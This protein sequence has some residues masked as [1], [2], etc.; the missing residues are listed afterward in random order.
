MSQKYKNIAPNNNNINKNNL[1]NNNF[2]KSS[3][4]IFQHNWIEDR[5]ECIKNIKTNIQYDYL[6][7]V[8]RKE[9]VDEIVAVMTNAI[10]SNKETISIGGEQIPKYE[11]EKRLLLLD[12]GH[13]EYVYECLKKCRTQIK[14]MSAYLLSCLYHA[15]DVI[16]LHYVNMVNT[17]RLVAQ[18]L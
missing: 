17:D 2:N 12:C 9:I 7:T 6:V 5:I 13:I 8:F 14:N 1:N 16:N 18:G 3:Y 15:T 4:H 10:C 11:V